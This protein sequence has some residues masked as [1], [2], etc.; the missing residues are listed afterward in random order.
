[1]ML[2][3]PSLLM[4]TAGAATISVIAHG[5]SSSASAAEEKPAKTVEQTRLGSAIQADLAKRD[6]AENKR[7]RDLDLRE[8]VLKASQKRIDASLKEK[9]TAQAPADSQRKTAVPTTAE[10]DAT[11]DQL[12][13]IYQS[14]KAKKAAVVFEKLDLEVQLAVA[15]KMRERSTAQI[16]AEMTPSGAARLSMALAGRRPQRVKIAVQK[17]GQTEAAPSKVTDK[18]GK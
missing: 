6:K 2:R 9:Q 17:A 4:L 10:Q 1:M 11:F 18:S 12:A 14:M 5:V 15:R 7:A 16:L 13:R 3:R 8:Q